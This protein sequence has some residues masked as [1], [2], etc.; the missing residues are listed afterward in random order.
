MNSGFSKG[1]ANNSGKGDGI[2]GSKNFT[3]KSHQS[4][5]IGNSNFSGSGAFKHPTQDANAAIAKAITTNE[6]GAYSKIITTTT[7]HK[8]RIVGFNGSPVMENH[9]QQ[10]FVDTKYSLLTQDSKDEIYKASLLKNAKTP[11]ISGTHSSSI[12][13]EKKTTAYK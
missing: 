5:N 7:I 10:R 11:V 9:S 12:E 2:F 8:Q 13:I 3:Y 1:G 6:K 4:G